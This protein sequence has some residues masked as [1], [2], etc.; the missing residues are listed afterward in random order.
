MLGF[1]PLIVLGAAAALFF[2][3]WLMGDHHGAGAVQAR[4]DHEKTIQ[5]GAVI[6][7]D[8]KV[9]TATAQQASDAQA[10]GVAVN[11]ETE[12]IHEKAKQIIV[13]VP[14]YV[15]AAADARC[16]VNAGFVRMWNDAN[17]AGGEVSP[18][19]DGGQQL[20]PKA[21]GSGS[22]GPAAAFSLDGK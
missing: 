8:E 2:G 4:W 3:G 12:V 21:E 16:S 14:V 15:P 5:Q 19:A 20:A 17:G 6:K 22:L 18:G 11:H 1:N 7:Q 9:I 13:R 10:I